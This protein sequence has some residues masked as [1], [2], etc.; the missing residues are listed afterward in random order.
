V[1]VAFQV[2]GR[3]LCQVLGFTSRSPQSL[4][5]W[6]HPFRRVKAKD[7]GGGIQLGPVNLGG[8]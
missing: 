3:R 8:E 2:A 5:S 1:Q 4:A 7:S 6:A